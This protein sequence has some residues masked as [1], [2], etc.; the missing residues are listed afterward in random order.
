MLNSASRDQ[1]RGRSGGRQGRQAVPAGPAHRV[2]SSQQ[3]NRPGDGNDNTTR[4][5]ERHYWLVPV[6]RGQL[7]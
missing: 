7:K 6:D 3:D 1:E 5:G 4:V 2:S